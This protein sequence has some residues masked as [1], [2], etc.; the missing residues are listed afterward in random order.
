MARLILTGEP[1]ADVGP[2]TTFDVTGTNAAETINVA[3]N[4]KATFDGSF[5]RGNDIINIA[6]NAAT[7]QIRL[8]SSNTALITNATGASLTIPVGTGVTIKFADADAR[9]LQFNTSGAA[10][11][12]TQAL[13]GTAVTVAAGNVVVPPPVGNLQDLNFT[14]DNLTG[15]AGVDTF[16]ADIVQNNNGEQTNSLG[17]GDRLE[18]L[19]GVD[20]LSATIQEASALNS[21]PNAA[22]APIT[23]S[24][25]EI[26]VAALHALAAPDSAYH[27]ND[28]LLNLGVQ[29]NAR[30]M[31]GVTDFGS[32][33]SD[34]SLTF[35]NVNTLNSGSVIGDDN[36]RITAAMTV[37]MDHSGPSSPNDDAANLTVLFD[38]DYL[39]REAPTEAGSQLRLQLLDI[40]NQ[41]TT[42]QPLRTN[43]FDQLRFTR[44]ING[45]VETYTISYNPT[46]TLTNKA[47]YDELAAR[48]NAALDANP[49]LVALDAVVTTVFTVVDPDGN[50][51]GQASGFN[52]V[53]TNSGP[54]Q[55]DAVGFL[56]SGIVPPNTDYQK[57]VFAER[58]SLSTDLITVD[59]ELEK[60][61]R[62]GDG[63]YLTIGGMAQ[64]PDAQYA[65][66]LL[67]NSIDNGTL[68]D[69]PGVERFNVKVE[70]NVD[71]P[72]S[73]AGL[74]STHNSL[75][76][77]QVTNPGSTASL[78]I[79]NSNTEGNGFGGGLSTVRNNAVKDVLI[80]DASAFTANS[81]VWAHFSDETV[82]K[83]LN[84]QDTQGDA[85]A[86]NVDSPFL[87][88][89][90]SFGGGN[91]VLNLNVSKSNVE[92]R[93]AITR[94]DF[95]L[96]IDMGAGN[97]TVELQ[98]GD[99]IEFS[100]ASNSSIGSNNWF[101][102]HVINEF[103]YV[104][105]TAI[106]NDRYVDS[107]VNVYTQSG[108][109]TVRLWGA[110][111]VHAELGDGNDTAYTDNSATKAQW[112]FNEL[113]DFHAVSDLHS[114]PRLIV[115]TPSLGA[116]DLTTGVNN[117][118]LTVSFQ[119]I[120]SSVFVSGYTGA[121]A[122][123]AVV[124][125]TTSA[126]IRSLTDLQI[127]QAIKDAINN[128]PVLNK[129]LIARD[130]P[131]GTLIVDAL[132][133]GAH[134]NT[135]LSLIL[136]STPLTAGQTGR[137]LTAGEVTNIG[138]DPATGFALGNVGNAVN[139][140]LDPSTYV[141]ATNDD[142]RWFSDFG[143]SSGS[144][145]IHANVNV[146]EGGT[147]NDVIV[148]SSN[149]PAALNDGSTETIDIDGVFTT[150]TGRDTI[151]NFQ[152]AVPTGGTSETQT[153]TFTGTATVNGSVNF[154]EPPVGNG[155][156]IDIAG[157]NLVIPSIGF[158][159]GQTAAQIADAVA[160]AI[161]TAANN[162]PTAGT[163]DNIVNATSAGGVVTLAYA[164]TGNIPQSSVAITGGAAT[165]EVNT[166]TLTG[167]NTLDPGTASITFDGVNFGAIAIGA[168]QTVDQ[169]GAALAATVTGSA[170]AV[171]NAGANTIVITSTTG[172]DKVNAVL[173]VAQQDTPPGNT[174]VALTGT[175][176]ETTPGAVGS[177]GISVASATTADGAAGIG[178][179]DIFD[180]TTVI[181]T[182]ATFVNDAPQNG[183][184]PDGALYNEGARLEF[185]TRNNANVT[186]TDTVSLGD[187]T[188]YSA[189]LPAATATTPELTLVQ[190]IVR[191]A[192]NAATLP[193]ANGTV[194]ILKSI[195]ITVDT[196]NVGHFYLIT[197]GA[198]AG[199]A[200]AELL[201]NIELAQYDS[202][203]K[204]GIGDWDTMTLQNFIPLTFASAT[205]TFAGV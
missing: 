184:E 143:V 67:T 69:E 5:N 177:T 106:N 117:I 147:G 121:N 58:P 101:T 110:T 57:Q 144:D 146:I 98:F 60:V 62:S 50:P 141:G 123:G 32:V 14:R 159:A 176:V 167:D 160:V 12:G 43:P 3:Q 125:S 195:V 39:L 187:Y 133:D 103:R 49:A 87:N 53:I 47:A 96:D 157:T 88:A 44:T 90:Y 135:D 29:V 35:Y 205:G 1:A 45:V 200:T 64:T 27:G 13:S 55:L 97:D 126:G 68:T 91:N 201:G 36:G 109:D 107:Q 77:V 158:S 11:L 89:R 154:G 111:A 204:A 190:N 66:T 70:G 65:G 115:N 153:I 198:A 161:N 51:G 168:G 16:R 25:E 127:N 2:S 42:S 118:R 74:Q 34:A 75:V 41:I 15:T 48:I 124:S 134:V 194:P 31:K 26:Y 21:S 79:G 54:G 171:Y 78:T 93:G 18:G 188:A 113:D 163:G 140:S 132:V 81:T 185:A 8:I 148:L 193:L 38:N 183:A 175:T 192:D 131:S 164:N 112:V 197:N 150:L 173:N 104:G 94:E 179:Y 30:D 182:V 56:A 105:G 7:Y 20:R 151:L 84:L 174:N 86:D 155:V 92:F 186:I 156:N 4:G 59:V 178:G 119:D 145:S 82:D 28:K 137:L 114:Q 6:G 139:P 180:V 52:I 149:G 120:V 172:G 181:G 37:R 22:I 19:G 46:S 202:A 63:G 128:D 122:T 72:S 165:N 10:V 100:G 136:T 166:I 40:D 95:E 199:D 191:A 152:A 80:F 203:T 71:Q 76:Y 129:L 196:E 130:G 102:N 17:T 83:Y 24:V 116:A 61:G 73:L 142:D 189:L 169:V 99:G 33:N 170:T 138:F 9:I 162:G 23:N 85:R 108:D